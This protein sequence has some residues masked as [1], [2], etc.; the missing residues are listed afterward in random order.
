[1]NWAQAASL[2]QRGALGIYYKNCTPEQLRELIY[3]RNSL[4]YGDRLGPTYDFLRK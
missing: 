4:K 1:M 3:Y 2:R